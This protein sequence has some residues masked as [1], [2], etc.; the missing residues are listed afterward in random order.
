MAMEIG[1]PP[2]FDPDHDF[3]RGDLGAKVELIE[4]GDYASPYS[5]RV[6]KILRRISDRF[7]SQTVFVFRQALSNA[8]PNA[9]EETI[10]RAAIA[11]GR[12]GLFWEMH[13]AIF[14]KRDARPTDEEIGEIAASI[15]LDVDRFWRDVGSEET[16]RHL[17]IDRRSGEAAGV[18]VTPTL[19]VSG[20]R[21]LGAW[22]ELAILEAIE[23]PFGERIRSARD[24]FF[25]WAAS[26]GFVLV[27][28]TLAALV[29][30]NIGLAEPYERLRETAFALSFGD[31]T[32]SLPLEVWIND[33][34]MT[35]FFLLVGIEIKREIV[36]G[37]LADL[38][39]ALLPIVGALGGM[40]APALVYTAFN[41]GGDAAHGW[42]IPM[43]TD[44]AFTLG[45]MALLGSRVP[46]A[47]KV[48]VSA[49]AIADDLGAIVV[50]AIFY[51]GTIHVVPLLVSAAILIVMALLNRGRVYALAP[52]LILGVILW[53][54]IFASGLH[55]TLAG[56][57]TA[58]LIPSRRTANI[59][60]VAAQASAIFELENRLQNDER[61]EV[62]HRAIGVL[63]N[64]LA[65]LREPGHHL[66][67]ALESWTNYTIL[68][69]FAFFN[70][71]VV[72]AGAH[73]S[74]LAPESLGVMLGLFLGKPVGIVL[75]CLIAVKF[76]W[77]RLSPDVTWPHMV[78]AGCLAGVGFTMSIFIATAAFADGQLAAVKLAILLGSLASAV[79]GM[80]ILSRVG[81]SRTGSTTP[82]A[83]RSR[84][85][86][87][88][89]A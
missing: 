31:R 88:A 62:S 15:G 2:R 72:M 23:R 47:L 27:L 73:F 82:E 1:R 41:F 71:G 50:I 81:G 52:Y 67:R 12:Q 74:P 35:V 22:D 68:P 16:T 26:A 83:E 36:N 64:A 44:I 65:R 25:G 84:G 57:L 58:A 19:F 86:V 17:E 32:F 9:C 20:E 38:S 10:T 69:L 29:A 76:G 4:Y 77:A 54:A 43:A 51:G 80:V 13:T 60:G 70:T 37:E 30:V 63:E 56:V 28:A 3:Y 21:Y 7:G 14:D 42:G 59:A 45:L 53:A 75:A 46:N 55:A 39:T 5:F 11:A 49:L 79:L 24:R 66:Q 48:F 8:D 34:L 18:V 78:G 61:G 87:P 40:V 6:H 85:D 89:D 33:G